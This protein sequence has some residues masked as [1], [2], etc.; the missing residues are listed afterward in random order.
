VTVSGWS[1]SVFVLVWRACEAE[2]IVPDDDS[3]SVMSEAMGV[4]TINC[5][6]TKLHGSR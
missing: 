4:K 5:A 3:L 1:A 6:R 2:P